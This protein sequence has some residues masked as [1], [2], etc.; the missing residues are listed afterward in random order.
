MTL[1]LTCGNDAPYPFARVLLIIMKWARLAILSLWLAPANVQADLVLTDVFDFFGDNGARPTGMVVGRDGSVY[2]TTARGGCHDLGSILQITPQ[3]VPTTLHHFAGGQDGALPVAPL[4]QASDGS[5]YGTTS[6]GGH[7]GWGTIFRV[8][9]NGEFATLASFGPSIGFE[10]G[11]ALVQGNDGNLYGTASPSACSG[12]FGSVFRITTDGN[13]TALLTLQEGYDMQGLLMGSDGNFYGVTQDRS[14]VEPRGTVLKILPGGTP[15]TLAVMGGAYP[16]TLLQSADGNFYGT[17]ASSST[18]AGTVFRMTASGSVFTLASLADPNGI[19][20]INPYVL[21]EGSDGILYG[22]AQFA[23]SYDGGTI[24]SVTPE[25]QFEPLASPAFAPSYLRIFDQPTLVEVT[26]GTFWGSS[27]SG[28]AYGLGLIFSFRVPEHP[29]A[30][31]SISKVDGRVI[32]TWRSTVGRQ[33]QV[34]Y[35]CGFIETNWTDLASAMIATDRL[36]TVSDAS[37][38]SQRFYRLSLLP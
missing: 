13:L 6:S 33:Y 10:R 38:Q 17:T 4:V 34:Q 24:F 5:F 25:G 3:G 27:S 8:T 20:G 1:Q 35:N 31:Q 32:L 16:A 7:V 30:F 36:T 15:T 19:N 21:V 22:M 9:T 18:S 29:P 2:V 28:G 26:K 11:F 12:C 14:G 37:D 23:G